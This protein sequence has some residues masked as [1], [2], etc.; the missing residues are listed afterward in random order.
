ME[1]EIKTRKRLSLAGSKTGKSLI[2]CVPKEICIQWGFV[3]NEGVTD[4]RDVVLEFK[5][6]VLTIRPYEEDKS[7][8]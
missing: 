1:F 8:E 7:K 2:L 5:N 3:S 4:K 6:N